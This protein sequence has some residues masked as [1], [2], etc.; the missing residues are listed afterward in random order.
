[1]K[2]RKNWIV[3]ATVMVICGVTTIA[4]AEAPWKKLI[5][6]KRHVEANANKDY[7]LTED[8]GPWMILATSFAGPGAMQQ[9]RDL[10]FELR[11][12]FGLPAF[13]HRKQFDYTHPVYGLGVDRYGRRK[14]MRYANATKFDEIAVVVGN[15]ASYEDPRAQ[16]D[17]E[18]I[19]RVQPDCLDLAKKKGKTTQRYIGLREI[20][21][22]VHLDPK[23]HDLGPMRR[24]FIG[25]NPLL[26]KEFFVL[27]G[28]DSLLVE[29][30]K[31]VKY[32]LFNNPG[33]YTVRVA[34]FRGETYFEGEE[35]KNPDIKKRVSVLGLPIGHETTKL[36]EAAEQAHK[37]TMALRARGVEAYEYHK[38][39]ESIV[40]IGSFA[41]SV[42]PEPNGVAL[43]NPAMLKIIKTYGAKRLKLPKGEA[44]LK[45]ITIEG[46]SLDVQPWPI[47]VP[48]MSL[49]ST[50]TARN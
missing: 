17:L 4:T 20:Q 5:P 13:M 21:R 16:A 40:T 29:M 32:S 12:R 28:P 19:K 36:E 26:P 23:K 45:P 1:M 43:V 24:A 6:F 39:H 35:K 8:Q 49:A 30:N 33:K 47:E 11:D 37:L 15:Y 50:Y 42:T 34:T 18:E 46:I 14:R 25:R 7:W 2:R 44:G 31:N 48:R 10:V 27:D 3:W 41:T 22:L 38:R 9:A